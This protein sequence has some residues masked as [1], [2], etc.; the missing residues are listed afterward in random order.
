[1]Y[2]TCLQEWIT[3]LLNKVRHTESNSYLQNPLLQCFKEV[4]TMSWECKDILS[5]IS[6]QIWV[7]NPQMVIDTPRY[8]PYWERN[9]WVRKEENTWREKTKTST[10]TYSSMELRL[11]AYSSTPIQVMSTRHYFHLMFLLSFANISHFRFLN[12]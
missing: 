12:T 5:F 11:P 9:A 1:M 6:I 10:G 3:H 2:I 7:E 4:T 8:I